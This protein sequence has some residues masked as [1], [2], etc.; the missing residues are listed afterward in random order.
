MQTI[1]TPAN[2]NVALPYKVASAGIRI[3]AFLLDSILLAIYLTIL[4][5]IR[6]G[7][8]TDDNLI[9]WTFVLIP[10][11]A[12]GLIFELIMDGQTPGKRIMRIRVI[13][14]D[15][16]KPDVVHYFLRWIFGLIDFI[17]LFGAV[18]TITI[19]SG[20]RGQRLGDIIA[21]TC[22]VRLHPRVARTEGL[23]SESYVPA[24]PQ[25]IH[26]DSYYLELIQRALVAHHDHDN[27]APIMIVTQ[28]IKSLFGI[29]SDMLPDQFLVTVVKDFNHLNA[30]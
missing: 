27:S 20:G 10:M 22:V 9:W 1:S 19:A 4:F 26:L 3:L 11:F 7:M 28:K 14:L 24:F 23:S 15:G 17:F 13:K 5:F 8:S 16:T 30:R 12:F 25:V 21:G 2:H 6:T 29:Q 18:A